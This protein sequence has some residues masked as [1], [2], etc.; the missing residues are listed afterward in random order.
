MEILPVGST[1]DRSHARAA[2]MGAAWADPSRPADRA[3]APALISIVRLLHDAGQALPGNRDEARRCIEK[4]AALVRGELAPGGPGADTARS[5]G[6][7][8][9]AP[10]QVARVTAFVDANLSCRIRVDSLAALARL[11]ASYFSRA[12]HAT[13]GASPN[14]YVIRRRIARAQELI[15]LTG[16]PLSEIALDCGFAD[17]AH[18]C[19]HFRRIVGASPSAWRRLHGPAAETVARPHRPNRGTLERSAVTE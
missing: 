4:A 11:S 2:A 15:S 18:L 5:T 17:Q 10:W 13:V 19:R 12:F 6:P 9:L 14:A 8:P 16:K 3:P 7:T 1:V